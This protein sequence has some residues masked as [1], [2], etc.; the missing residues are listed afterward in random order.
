MRGTPSRRR[1]LAGAAAGGTLAATGAAAEDPVWSAEYWAEKGPVRLSLY[2]KRLGAPRAGETT[3][4]VLFLVHGSSN[5]ARSS[6]D[7]T[8]PGKGEYSLMNVFARLGYDVWTMDHENY[9]RSSRTGSNSAIASGAAD[10]AAAAPVVARETGAARFHFAGE[11]SGALRAAVFAA[12]EPAR[13]DRL[14]L[15]AF[16]Y[17]GKD[18][19][20]LAERAKRLP[21]WRAQATRLRD[22]AMI[23]SIFTR[24]APGTSDMAVAEALADAELV[25]GDRIPTGTYLDMTAN[26]PVVRPED[27]TSPV[28]LIRGEHDGIA[29]LADLQDFFGRLPNGD[30]QFV[31]L[32][33]AAHALQYGM[34]RHQ[35]WHAVHAFLSLPPAVAA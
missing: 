29:S 7:L 1:V 12:R 24:D 18:S 10:L 5:S 19:P 17:T 11:S 21:E 14:V 16:T 33:H 26:L 34:N 2:R 25:F 27:V 15:S 6:F 35:Y 31:T 8:V 13:V 4:P 9:G 32:S 3:R 20:T 22:R 28:L 30:R 23:R